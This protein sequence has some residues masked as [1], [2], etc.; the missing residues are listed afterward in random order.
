[1]GLSEITLKKLLED[2]QQY[3]LT[4]PLFTLDGVIF[5]SSHHLQAGKVNEIRGL[6]L[7]TS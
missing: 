5:Q 4:E 7:G 1:M 3:A 6:S 2:Q